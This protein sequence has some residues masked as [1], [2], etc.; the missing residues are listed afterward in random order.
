MNYNMLAQQVPQDSDGVLFD[1]A[2]LYAQFLPL[3]DPRKRRGRRYS[4][5]LGL[6]AMFLAKLVHRGSD[7]PRVAAQNQP[8]S[9]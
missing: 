8:K 6:V 1:V 2:S 4:L 3:P 9:R 7:G 5:A